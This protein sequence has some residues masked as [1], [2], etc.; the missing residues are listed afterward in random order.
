MGHFLG[1]ESEVAVHD[2]VRTRLGILQAVPVVGPCL[3][4]RENLFTET[5]MN[6][7]TDN[8]K[9]MGVQSKETVDLAA[10]AGRI[11]SAAGGPV[12]RPSYSHRRTFSADIW[13]ACA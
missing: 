9:P 8:L 10:P 13:V 1:E 6:N 2:T 7:P 12:R 11:Y 3:A 4:E 5:L